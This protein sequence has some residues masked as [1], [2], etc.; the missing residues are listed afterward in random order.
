MLIPGVM[1]ISVLPI[2]T[3]WPGDGFSQ[4]FYSNPKL[5]IQ[6]PFGTT[7]HNLM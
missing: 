6:E 1:Y 5:Q 4:R 7:K 2:C 3:A